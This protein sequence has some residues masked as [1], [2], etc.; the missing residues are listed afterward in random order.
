MTTGRDPDLRIVAL[1]GDLMDRSR[2]TTA[3]V[4]IEIIKEPE[5]AR[6]AACIVVDL[7]LGV[8][9][10]AA[11]R[12]SAPR[13]RIVAYGRHTDVDALNA[14]TAAGADDAMPRS[15]FFRDPAAA[16]GPYG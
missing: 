12:A 13:A 4:G 11:L 2:L 16:L 15:R 14:A 3:I 10:V 6:D 5:Q 9:S 8:G 1:V 7:A